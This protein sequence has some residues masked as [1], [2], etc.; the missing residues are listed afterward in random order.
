M[1]VCIYYI[2]THI[3]HI[4]IIYTYIYMYLDLGVGILQSV[5][6]WVIVNVCIGER[7]ETSNRRNS[8]THGLFLLCVSVL[9]PGATF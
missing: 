6:E 7:V 2:Y 3:L 4:C 9:P 5:T 1:Y 8:S